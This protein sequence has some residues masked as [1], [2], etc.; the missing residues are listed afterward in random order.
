MSQKNE[1]HNSEP[2]NKN[3]DLSVDNLPFSLLTM[4]IDQHKKHLECLVVE[5]I[6]LNYDNLYFLF[7]VKIYYM[8]QWMIII[9]G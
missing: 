6:F 4:L 2:Q 3:E 5:E 9:S 8:R 1:S 7:R